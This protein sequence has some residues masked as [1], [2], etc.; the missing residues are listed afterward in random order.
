MAVNHI[1][2]GSGGV[3]NLSGLA[4]TGKTTISELYK[5]A[6][7]SEGMVL[8]GVCVSNKAAQKLEVESG[9]EA[10]SGCSA[11]FALRSWEYSAFT[12]LRRATNPSQSR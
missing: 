7:E 5:E 1:C 6:L 4:G 12:R 8:L 9:M 2:R 10:R 11:V 3:A